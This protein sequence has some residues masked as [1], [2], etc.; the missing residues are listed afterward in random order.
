MGTTPI[1]GFPYPDPSDL[2]A[3]YPA[4]GQDLAEDIEAVLPTLGGISPVPP[5]TIANSGGSASTTANTTTFTTVNSISLNG[6]FTADYANY[7][8]VMKV[9]ASASNAFLFRLRAAGTDSSGSNYIYQNMYGYNGANVAGSGA[10]PATSGRFGAISTTNCLLTAD[11]SSPQKTETKSATGTVARWTGSIME[12]YTEGN[13]MAQTTAFDG[14]T[15]FPAAGTMT[16]TV[17]I[18][19]YKG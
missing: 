6:I 12:I 2:V 18:Y 14:I 11:I 3:N 15:F 19:G 1:Y 17:S 5:T 4:M 16:G 8:I 7:R 9:L 13:Y 10:V